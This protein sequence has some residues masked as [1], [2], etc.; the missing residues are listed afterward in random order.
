MHGERCHLPEQSWRDN[1]KLGGSIVAWLGLRRFHM[2][3]LCYAVF[4]RSNPIILKSEV[5]FPGEAWLFAEEAKG[6]GR[7]GGK[8]QG[9]GESKE[10]KIVI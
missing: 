4:Q 6:T 10:G 7:T 5:L 2:L 9:Q 8:C 3:L 1:I